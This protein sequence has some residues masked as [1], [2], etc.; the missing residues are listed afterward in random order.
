MSGPGPGAPTIA[1][2]RL[3]LGK[4]A[5]AQGLTLGGDRKLQRIED[6]VGFLYQE[7]P[8]AGNGERSGGRESS[9]LTVPAWVDGVSELF[10]RQAQEVLQRELV[11]RRGIRQLLDQP[12]LLEKVEPNVEIVKT[13]LTHKDLLNEKTRGLARKIIEQVVEQLKRRMQVQVEAAITGAMR[14]D[15]HSPRRAFRNLDVKTTLRR[16]LENFDQES[17]RLL[18]DRLYFF[19]AERRRRPW[20]IVIAVDQS[21]SMLDSAIFS[22]VMASIFF[23][24]PAVRTSLFLFD[25][26]VVDLSDQVGQPVD[27]LLRVQLGGGTNIA[28][29]MRYAGQLV[30]EPARTIVVLITDFYEGGSEQVLVQQTGDMAQAGVRL[31]GLGALGYDARPSYN[32][33]LAKK[34]RKMGMDV[35]V[36]TPEKLAD[37]MARIIRG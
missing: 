4:E 29:A 27:V 26:Q 37:C 5:E 12:E 13:L 14:R 15:R 8:D 32:R 7:A 31:I 23:E 28:Q 16:N 22:T 3:V 1:R 10:P 20:H 2:W 30:R 18:V 25:T 24:L 6:L 36:C 19:A 21:G 34:L 11:K 35:L 17:G 9:R 33:T